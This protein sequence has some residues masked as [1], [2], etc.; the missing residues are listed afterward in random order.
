MA[1]ALAAVVS[2][3]FVPALAVSVD[4]VAAAR[5]PAVDCDATTLGAVAVA[6][7]LDGGD[8]AAA[9]LASVAAAGG[10][11]VSSRSQENSNH[12]KRSIQQ[13]PDSGLAKN[14]MASVNFKW[15]GQG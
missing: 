2:V 11:P 3:V 1:T 13:P 15:D 14:Q 7:H 9:A 5:A 10:A 6:H 8:P 12:H 4:S